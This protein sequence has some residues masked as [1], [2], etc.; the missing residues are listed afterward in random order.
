MDWKDIEKLNAYGHGVKAKSEKTHQEFISVVSEVLAKRGHRADLVVTANT[1]M[2][3]ITNVEIR[4]KTNLG[5]P[6]EKDLMSL[7]AKHFAGKEIDWDTVTVDTD[8][9]TISLNLVNSTEMIPIKNVASIPKGF[10]P[11]GTA[12]YRRA[13]DPNN[14]V[15]EIWSLRKDDDGNLALFRNHDD[16]EITADKDEHKFIAGDV[17]DTPYGPGKIVRFDDLGNAIVLVGSKKRLVAAEE[18]KPYNIEREK[19][20]LIDYY[21]QAYGDPNFA[22]ALVEKYSEV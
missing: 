20:K 1:K 8:A 3:D 10:T 14:D 12:L 17:V 16:V 4:Y 19:Q 9:G 18:I 6:T 5:Y 21:A 13:L 7:V 22:K 15:Y 2:G 11:I